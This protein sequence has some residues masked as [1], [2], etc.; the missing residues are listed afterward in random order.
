[1]LTKTTKLFSGKKVTNYYLTG[2]KIID[3]NLFTNICN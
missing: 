3:T 2:D 1:M